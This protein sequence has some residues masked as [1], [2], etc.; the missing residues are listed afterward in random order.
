MIISLKK[1]I[2]LAIATLTVVS[3][4]IIRAAGMVPETAV[5]LVDANAGE[6]TIT[7][8]NTD[9]EPA[10][11]Y[12]LVENV[13]DDPEDMVLV[14][15][16]V[17]LVD[18]GDKQLIRF[19]IHYDK[20]ITRQHLKRAVFEGIPSRSPSDNPVINVNIRQNLPL[21]ITPAGLPEKSDPWRLLH[22]SVNGQSL[23]VKNDSLYVVR[24][25]EDLEIQ[26]HNI[27]LKLPQPYILPGASY[28]LPIP[29][30]VSLDK[31]ATVQIQPVSTY[32]FKVANYDAAIQH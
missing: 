20:P 21:I 12:S 30:Q 3:T 8:T 2:A 32:G 17:T 16:P 24:L 28:T 7:I 6:G 14:T 23:T 25:Y 10:L 11:L 9:K 1:V 22:W 31:A 15:Q 4:P 27:K 13:E 19:V 5:V 26:P 29:G 18:P